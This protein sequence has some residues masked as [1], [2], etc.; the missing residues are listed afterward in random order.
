MN[1]AVTKHKAWVAYAGALAIVLVTLLTDPNVV[2][3]IPEKLRPWLTTVTAVATALGVRQVRNRPV[4]AVDN[5]VEEHAAQD[6]VPPVP[7]PSEDYEETLDANS[8]PAADAFP[9]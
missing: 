6:E 1:E 5:G 4:I 7:V 3:L 8:D 2:E 9:L